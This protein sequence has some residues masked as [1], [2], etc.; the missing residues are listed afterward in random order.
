MALAEDKD[1][2]KGFPQEPPPANRLSRL[3]VC[4][5]S[6]PLD[7]LQDDNPPT[8]EADMKVILAPLLALTSVL[9]VAQTPP[10]STSPPSNKE[11]SSSMRDPSTTGTANYSEGS[12]DN[13]SQM[14][15]C[16]AKAKADHPQMSPADMKRMCEKLKPK[17]EQ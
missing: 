7:G 4:R 11:P 10:S 2:P 13:K 16:L 14:K 12:G 1:S 3:H 6:T 8:S 5:T 9:A 17:G 15:A